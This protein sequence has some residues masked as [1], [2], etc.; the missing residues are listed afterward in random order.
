MKIKLLSILLTSTVS[1]VVFAEGVTTQQAPA[2]ENT[3]FYQSTINKL[4]QSTDQEEQTALSI[5]WTKYLSFSGAMYA[6]AKGGD[7]SYDTQGENS[8]RLS[9]T[10]AHVTAQ[11]TP[12][13]WS[14]LTLVTNYSG[15]SSSY[16]AN[17]DDLDIASNP[18]KSTTNNPL[19]VD[20]A[21]V[22]FGDESRYPVFAQIG[23]QYLPFG[24]Y[25]VNP[26]VK[27][28]SQML[29]ETNATDAQ[30]GFVTPQGLYGSAYV[31]QNPLSSDSN[32][33][34]SSPYNGGAV[35]GFKKSNEEMVFDAGLGYMNDMSGVDSIA[36][37][38]ETVPNNG[39]GGGYGSSVSAL[40]P[41]ASFQTGPFGINVDYVT[42]LS[43]FDQASLPYETT[44]DNGAKPSAIDS[45]VSYAFNVKDMDQVLFVGYQ[46]SDQ[47]SALNLPKKR[48]DVGYN[49]Y[50]LKN[51][52]VGLEVT[53]DTNYGGSSTADAG[54][55]A[56][57]EK[58]YTY[59]ARVGLQF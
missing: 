10:N 54:D 4:N 27:S 1:S 48:Y 26:A 37:Y 35:L 3:S 50:P 43:Y 28:L 36:N 14:Q 56:D 23:K 9:V 21:Y 22:T 33:S 38:M 40:A 18:D 52:L 41:Y 11:A 31:F 24:Q 42:A 58:Y 17:P 6:D 39:A 49:L 2:T 45:Q 47:A 20:Q 25:D 15:A 57:G 32:T 29:T 19:Y 16:Q 53:Q 51:V 7:Q 5:D 46:I 30:L 12:N 55:T 59:N 34:N 44:S 8:N 13:T